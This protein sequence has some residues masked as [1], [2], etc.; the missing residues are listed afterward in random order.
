MMEDGPM[1]AI[2]RGTSR[3]EAGVMSNDKT[4][5]NVWLPTPNACVKD[6]I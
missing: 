6:P 2:Q 3:T 5:L 1:A 4:N